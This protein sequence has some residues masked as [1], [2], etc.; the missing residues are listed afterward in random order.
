MKLPLHRF[1]WYILCQTTIQCIFNIES[2]LS[3]SVEE[4]GIYCQFKKITRTFNSIGGAA[5]ILQLFSIVCDIGLLS[6][7]LS[8][9]NTLVNLYNDP[10][11]WVFNYVLLS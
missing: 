9:E 3:Y 7:P 5:Q 11:Q 1:S 6:I 4:F 8:E 10:I 2:G